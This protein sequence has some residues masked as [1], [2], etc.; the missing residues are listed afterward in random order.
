MDQQQQTAVHSL[1]D[2]QL[3]KPLL[4]HPSVIQDQCVVAKLLQA[5]KQLQEAVAQLLF[6]QLQAVLSAAKVRQAEA[7]MQWLAKHAGLLQGLE[8][9]LFS[10][11]E[12][13]GTKDWSEY[14]AALAATLQDAAA[15]GALEGLFSF[16]FKGATAISVLQALPAAQVAH[17]KVQV[18][19]YDALSLTAVA[20]LTS[21]RSLQLTFLPAS[22]GSSNMIHELLAA[23]QAA[24]QPLAAGLQQLTELHI[25]P[26]F[27]GQLQHLPPKLQQLHV[28][29]SLEGQLQQLLQLARW[30][31]QHGSIV[32]SLQL[33][34]FVHVYA[35]SSLPEQDWNSEMNYLGAALEAAAAPAA[36]TATAAAADGFSANSVPC[37]SLPL[38]SLSLWD[39][40][41]PIYTVTPALLQRLP[42]H[43]LTHLDLRFERNSP[44]E[45]AVLCRLTALRSLKFKDLPDHHGPRAVFGDSS[46]ALAPL[47][48]LQQL[49]ELQL[50]CVHRSQLAALHLPQLQQLRVDLTVNDKSHQLQICH[51]TALQK[52]HILDNSTHGLADGDQLPPSLLDVSWNSNGGCSVQPLLALTRLQML[53]LSFEGQAPAASELAQLSSLRSLQ[54]LGLWYWNAPAQVTAALAAEAWPVLSLVMLNIHAPIAPPPALLEHLS[55]LQRLNHLLCKGRHMGATP[56]QL[57]ALLR[58]LPSLQSVELQEHLNSTYKSPAC[59]NEDCIEGVQELLQAVSSLQDLS[60]VHVDVAVGLTA[61]E[62]QQVMGQLPQLLGAL[63]GCCRIAQQ[64]LPPGA[65]QRLR[66]YAV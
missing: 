32:S 45:R 39:F 42:A 55:V 1:N 14:T 44:V 64:R 5:S 19:C 35:F 12:H 18:P 20:A 63:A 52:L 48:A 13:G 61:D 33:V 56:G 9:Q 2:P 11:I 16:S 65:G 24:L 25:G 50:P 41:C 30:I 17:L 46:S 29:V 54:W 57:A 21:L 31:Q 4:L 43:S 23:Q 47:T 37:R 53:W 28:T 7:F 22:R 60:F 10:R 34:D 8:A 51:M 66:V 49:T 3:Y 27:A 40:C 38:E 62:A 26:V 6:G 58:Q 59:C 36:S 15:R